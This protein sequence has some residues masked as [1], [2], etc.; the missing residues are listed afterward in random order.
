MVGIGGASRVCRGIG[1]LAAGGICGGDWKGLRGQ[2][3]SAEHLERLG[4]RQHLWGASEVHG[5]DWEGKQGVSGVWEV[6]AESEGLGK[7]FPPPPETK[8]YF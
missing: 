8:G 7:V 2:A 1:E 3:E 6:L 5:G 4:D